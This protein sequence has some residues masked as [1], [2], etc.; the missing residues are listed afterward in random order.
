MSRGGNIVIKIDEKS[1]CDFS[2]CAFGASIIIVQMVV[3]PLKRFIAP[4]PRERMGD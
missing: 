3:R 2:C 4:A 1:F